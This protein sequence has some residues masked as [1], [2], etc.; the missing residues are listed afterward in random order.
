[1]LT[2][3]GELCPTSLY[4]EGK[5]SMAKRNFNMNLFMKRQLFTSFVLCS[6][7]LVGV[8]CSGKASQDGA[9]STNQ[10]PLDSMLAQRKADSLAQVAMADSVARAERMTAEI[11]LIKKLYSSPLIEMHQE[12]SKKKELSAFCSPRMLDELK[13]LYKKS[14]DIM[15]GD[16]AEGYLTTAFTSGDP[17]GYD[18]SFACTIIS[19]EPSGEHSYVV[20]YKHLGRK[21]QTELQMTSDDSEVKVDHILK[22]AR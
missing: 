11:D 19:V 5:Y 1:M 12:L 4:E 2:C 22:R 9:D 18:G 7:A 3:L 6:M 14:D 20:T 15:M 8:S 10:Q 21:C 16:P 13:A 17:S